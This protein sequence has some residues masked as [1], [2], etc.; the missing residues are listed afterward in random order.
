[1]HK[2][3][4]SSV[5]IIA[6]L[7]LGA[8]SSFPTG[9]NGGVIKPRQDRHPDFIGST[10][11]PHQPEHPA[12]PS[13]GT[14]FE[15]TG[16]LSGRMTS[17]RPGEHPLKRKPQPQVHHNIFYDIP[18]DPDLGPVVG[19]SL[20][21]HQGAQG[22]HVHTHSTPGSAHVHMHQDPGFAHNHHHHTQP[23]PTHKMWIHQPYVNGMKTQ[24]NHPLPN[25]G[26]HNPPVINHP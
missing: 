20:W 3:S 23:A 10:H 15:R 14:D 17:S 8:C 1:M 24:P 18:H 7:S 4:T 13:D 16:E 22:G 5:L 11:T 6:F 2:F 9:P 25:E 19:P 12:H 21:T 26:P